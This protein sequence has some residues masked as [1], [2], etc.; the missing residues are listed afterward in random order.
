MRYF[1]DVRSAATID[2]PSR[3]SPPRPETHE[4]WIVSVVFLSRRVTSNIDPSDLIPN[5]QRNVLA[6]DPTDSLIALGGGSLLV[7]FTFC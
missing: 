4:I 2:H 5:C 3:K 7:G 6:A 1:P